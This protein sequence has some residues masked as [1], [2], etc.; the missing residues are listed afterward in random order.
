[1][2]LLCRHFCSRTFSFSYVDIFVIVFRRTNNLFGP[3]SYRLRYFSKDKRKTLWGHNV[4]YCWGRGERRAATERNTGEGWEGKMKLRFVKFLTSH[5]NEIEKKE[6]G[7]RRSNI[8]CLAAT[9]PGRTQT[10][11]PAPTSV[12]FSSH[13]PILSPS[14]QPHQPAPPPLQFLL[15]H[16]SGKQ[17][18][19]AIPS[20]AVPP[21]SSFFIKLPKRESMEGRTVAGAQL[22]DPAVLLN[23]N[24]ARPA[25][26]TLAPSSN[27]VAAL[28]LPSP[29]AVHPHRVKP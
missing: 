5:E 3:P 9:Q 16:W 27:R 13:H 6:E 8:S 17:C 19:P 2:I 15:R 23:D 21:L 28:R 14:T 4:C 12:F 25:Y 10:S 11:A 7:G 18:P 26:R 24:R 29:G 20:P 1:M 22:A